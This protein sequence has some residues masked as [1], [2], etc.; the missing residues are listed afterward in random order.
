MRKPEVVALLK[1][2][3]EPYP[4][5]VRRLCIEATWKLA[6]RLDS[7]DLLVYDNY[8]FVVSGFTFTK[9]PSEAPLSLAVAWDH[10][11][12]CFLQG[13]HLNDPEKRLKGGGNLVRNVQLDSLELLE[14]PY[15]S[16]LI[17]QAIAVAKKGGSTGKA[18]LQ[19][20]SAKK[21]RPKPVG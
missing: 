1:D 18:V 13:V 10:V 16:G 20:V 17:D 6:Q 15:I 11:T 3:L 14:E 9:K 19:S 12:L 5:H 4:P 7:A 2:P 8:N 21:R